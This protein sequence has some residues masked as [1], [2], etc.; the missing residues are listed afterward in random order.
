MARIAT[1]A[2]DTD[3]IGTDK[4]IGTS[5]NTANA[6]KNFTVDA[7]AEFLNLSGIIESQALRY[8]YQDIIGNEVRRRGTISFDT[9]EG[10]TVSFSSV[11]TWRLSTYALTNKE[12]HTFYDAPLTGST[13]LVTNAENPQNWAIYLWNSSTQ[14]VLEPLF[15]DISLTYISGTG[16]L[17]AG[18]D[19]LISLLRYDVAGDS[20]KTFIFTQAVPNTVWNIAHTL[21]KYPSVSVVNNNNIIINGEVT[22]IDKNNVE[23]N[24]SAGFAGK[25]YLN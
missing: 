13:V 18:E 24:F 12:V 16:D 11:T 19:Y 21:D 14:N 15:Y 2:L 4:W 23:L 22:Y 17:I 25:A 3:I 6:T 5:V 7:V 1:Y 9:T 20:D 8:K 10:D